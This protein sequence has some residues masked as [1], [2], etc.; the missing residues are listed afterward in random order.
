MNILLIIIILLILLFAY[1]V[2]KLKKGSG[3]FSSFS[4]FFIVFIIIIFAFIFDNQKTGSL[5]DAIDR[6]KNMIHSPIVETN[7]FLQDNFHMSIIKIEDK[8]L[9]DADVISQLP[10]LPRGCEVT[11]L[12]MLLNHAGVNVNKMTLAQKIGKNPATYKE[13]DGKIYFG[14]PNDGFV[15][16]MYT[17]DDPGLGVYHSPIKRLAEKYL[18]HR[19][20]DLTGSDFDELKIH[21]SDGR[22][23][24]VIINTNYQKLPDSLFE[25]WNTPSGTIKI[26]YKEH[27]VLIT[28]YDQQ[29]VYFNDPLTGEKNQK[30]P[31]Q[32]FKDAW[33]QMGSQAITYLPK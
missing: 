9:I 25:T 29:Y 8:V 27:S 23:V 26:T 15:G 21:L 14:D 11:S 33:I 16:N 1:L 28:G 10:E 18:P 30:A 2:V 13:K 17:F 24:W 3:V 20:K 19:I 12:A 31:I 32:D 6:I 7:S 22:P 4:L 5:A